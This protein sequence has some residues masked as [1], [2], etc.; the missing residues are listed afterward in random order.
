MSVF[1][2]T[3]QA[4]RAAVLSCSSLLDWLFGFVAKREKTCTIHMLFC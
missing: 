1:S 2:E 4:N 3:T